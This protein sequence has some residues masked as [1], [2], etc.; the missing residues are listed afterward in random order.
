MDRI[1]VDSTTLAWV[2]YSP[3]KCLLELGFH[4][5]KAYGYFD[6]P[7]RTYQELLHAHSKGQYFNLHIR[8]HFRAEPVRTLVVASKT[9]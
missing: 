1:A 6:V 9:K 2:G 7:L 3:D 8:N 4:T 5:G